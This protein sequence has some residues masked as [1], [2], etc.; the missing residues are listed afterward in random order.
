MRQTTLALA[1]GAAFISAAQAEILP[2]Y[3]GE[4]IVVTPT[5]VP[6]ADVDAPF[7]SEV[8]TRSRIAESGAASLVDYLA[9]H[10]SV[11]VLSSY[12][13]TFTPRIDM[14]GYGI[15][16][17]Y[18]NIVVSLDG[19]RLNNIDG[20]P[21]LLG[22][23]PLADIER[24]EITKGSG[25]VL[26][27]DGATAGTIQIITRGH[28]GVSAEVSA[29]NHGARNTR[30]AAGLKREAFSLSASTDYGRLAGTSDP[31]INGNR[32]TSLNRSSQGRLEVHPLEGLTL[33]L[34]GGR[35]RIDTRYIGHLTLAEYNSDPAQNSGN[36]YTHQK[37]ETDVRGAGIAYAFNPQWRLTARYHSEDK[38]SDYVSFAFKAN[39]DN[40]SGDL[41]LEY[42]GA[43][44]S[45]TAGMQ[46]FEGVRIGSFDRTS[47]DNRGLFVQTQYQ[48]G[49]TRLSAGVRA[50]NISYRYIP[51]AGTSLDSDDTFFAW[52][53]G[54]NLGVNRSLS[55]FANYNQAFQA[56]DIDRFFDFGGTFNAF[57][58]PAKSRTLTAG[59]NHVTPAN[60]VKLA[61]FH[62]SLKDEI[63]LQPFTF[64]N[65]NLDK[66]HKYGLEVQD[67]WQIAPMLSA[68]VNYTYTRALI[69]RED[70]GGGGFDG[71]ELPGVP[72]H[73]VNLGLNWRITPASS[74]NLTHVWRASTWAAEDFDNNNLQKQQAY[75]STGIAYQHRHKNLEWFAA[76]DN[77]FE[78]PN[79]IWLRDDVIYPVN[80]TRSWRLG[81]KADF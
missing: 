68:S 74:L 81:M 53:L 70:S 34:D 77:V 55:L 3:V 32:D 61:V 67:R 14:R 21:Q 6:L 75:Q 69:D 78:K 37:F 57:I 5:R 59:L 63:Y 28:E 52:E 17:G 49:A 33:S 39:Y 27:G 12:G 15:G 20:A 43:A 40:R 47:K 66:T 10:T 25:S 2:E 71:K 35:S 23:I 73:G 56:P 64:I 30:F 29:G 51:T 42:R 46:A 72:R 24:I 31:D 54:V 65:T 36:T 9:Q 60:R 7:A 18:Q 26:F 11:Q 76:V 1:L 13:N 45:L 48:F 19:R 50:E 44:L 16:D 58:S 4:T 62:A 38:L 41:A 8:H 79:G 80:F 22:A